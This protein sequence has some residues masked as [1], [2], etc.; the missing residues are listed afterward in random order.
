VAA[1][2]I[3]RFPGKL[4]L[5]VSFAWALLAGLG[6]DAFRAR[7]DD[8]ARGP[9]VLGR[10]AIAAGLPALG[11]ALLV[12][13]FP[14][15]LA[16]TV[17]P[18][19][20]PGARVW[21]AV[22][23]D[24]L[25]CA[26]AAGAAVLAAGA[27]WLAGRRPAWATACAAG[28]ALLAVADLALPNRRVNPMVRPELIGRP[29]ETAQRL[30]AD[31]AS[32]VHVLEG[33]RRD[34]DP[35]VPLAPPEAL[36]L[37]LNVSLAGRSAS[38]W[39]LAGSLTTESLVAP[40]REQ[41]ALSRLFEA[42]PDGPSAVRLLQAGAV[43]HVL[44]RSVA[45]EGLRPL[46]TVPS[47]LLAPVVLLRVPE[48]LPRAY[49]VGAT[50]IASDDEALRFLVDPGADRRGTVV[51]ADGPALARPPAFA[52]ASRVT[53][54][55]PDDLQLE[56]EASADACL[57][58]VEAYDP[59]WTASVDGRPARVHRANFGFRAVAV[60]AGRH[61]VRLRY[62]PRAVT[63]GLAASAAT[64]GAALLALAGT[65]AKRPRPRGGP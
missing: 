40:T 27:A 60:P 14:G 55:R 5:F 54:W 52:G 43:S 63:L 20:P 13:A 31:G 59:G 21:D 64:L 53:R 3:L 46:A 38:R 58:L 51:L 35:R 39:G 4:T 62:R 57:V 23:L 15:A 9:G 7:A 2:S 17:V 19:P 1:V 32:R 30:H 41:L 49:V 28:L 42:A 6:L 25:L 44:A 48:P 29:P 18:P 26:A 16:G 45:P 65:R 11:F 8:P 12:V 33:E 61:S 50:A 56:V 36:A 47:P 37:G 24:A 34:L 22:W 10:T